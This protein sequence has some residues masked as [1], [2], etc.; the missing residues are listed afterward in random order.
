MW[1]L[2]TSSGGDGHGAQFP[3]ALPGRCIGLT[4]ECQDIVLDPFVGSG[5]SGV[6]TRKLGRRFIG[7]D[8]SEDYLKKAEDRLSAIEAPLL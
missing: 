1:V 4:T 7:I 6:A 5:N 2:S 3:L 8:V